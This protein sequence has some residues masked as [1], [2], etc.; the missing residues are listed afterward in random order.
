[1]YDDSTVKTVIG[2]TLFLYYR[3]PK[4]TKSIIRNLEHYML[5]N[6]LKR[7]ELIWTNLLCVSDIKV[8]SYKDCFLWG[9]NIEK[10]M[11]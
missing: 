4:N 2:Y 11:S 7:V 8:I 1:M 5:S 3:A 10:L 6:K 9:D